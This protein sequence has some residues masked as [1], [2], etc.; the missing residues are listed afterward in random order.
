MASHNHF[1]ATEARQLK[2][3]LKPY[4]RLQ[5]QARN[6]VSN[7]IAEHRE[8]FEAI[9]NGKEQEAERAL[10]EHVLIQGTRFSDFVSQ[11][12]RFGESSRTTA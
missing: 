12:K 6:R 2:Q 1:L 11:V 8:I 5:L 9:K 7:S 10:K 4:R 3:R